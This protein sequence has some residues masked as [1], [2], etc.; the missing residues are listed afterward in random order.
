SRSTRFRQTGA[1]RSRSSRSP[2]TTTPRRSGSSR[3]LPASQG[4]RTSNQID[5]ALRDTAAADESLGPYLAFW[6]PESHPP[7]TPT[8]GCSVRTFHGA[9]A[10][11]TA[12]ASA[13]VG[14]ASAALGRGLAG[15][16]L[17]AHRTDPARR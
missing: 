17:F 10:D 14:L 4:G 9:A 6:N 12:V 7:L 16:Y 2:R 15:G 3:S 8:I 1:C 5:T 11:A 13:A